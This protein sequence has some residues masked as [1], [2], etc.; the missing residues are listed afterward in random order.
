MN[1]I[2]T[3]GN[4]DKKPEEV[5]FSEAILNPSAS[6]GGLFCPK[7][8]P[9]LSLEDIQNL[10]EKNYKELSW[11]VWKDIFEIDI[12]NGEVQRA[13]DLYDYF[14]DPLNPAPLI[15]L[16][17]TLFVNELYHGPTR[18]F[19]DMALQPF[20]SLLSTLA[21]KSKENYLILAATSGD[22]GPA[23]LNTF[24]NKDNIK[25]VCIYPDGGTSDVQRL[26]MVTENG[27]NLKVIGIKGNFDDA[28]SALKNLL[29]SQSF[30]K[31]LSQN[32]LKLS[33][34]NSVNFGRIIF[35]IVYH[36]HS[37]L[38]LLRNNEVKLGEKIYLI[39]PSGNFGNA[40][41]GY[42]AKKMGFPIEK[43]LIA[44]NQ[45]NILTEWITTGIYDISNKSL[46]LTKS[47]A[48]RFTPSKSG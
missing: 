48:V 41:G 1:F 31:K 18:A 11:F 16:N 46:K 7:N 36:M 12:A 17:D 30:A 13:L 24:K 15:K 38:Q 28:Q 27:K 45:N 4:D 29:S 43:I 37:Y 44:S 6:F 3:R 20:G 21:K 40:L 34:A 19:K 5:A 8:L 47:P 26:Q 14:D 39:V 23:A 22:T 33:A 9:T 35:Q 25:V 2:E 42:Y 10:S 32:G